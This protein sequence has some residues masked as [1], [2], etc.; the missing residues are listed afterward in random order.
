MTP[1][2][3]DDIAL[4][5]SYKTEF[6]SFDAGNEENKPGDNEMISLKSVVCTGLAAVS[7]SWGCAYA[8][9][10]PVKPVNVIVPYGPGNGLDQLSREYAHAL[11]EQLNI[12]FV[13]ENKEGA[14]GVVGAM[15]AA[16]AAPDGY[17][18]MVAAHPP[19]ATAPLTQKNPGY[20]PLKSFA[21]IAR[22]GSVP[23]I[24]VTSSQSPIT[25]FDVLKSYANENPGKANYASSGIGSPGQ[26]N[27]EII[28]NSTKMNIQEVPYKSTSQALTDVVAGHVLVSIVSAPAAEQL[29]ASGKLRVLGVGSLERLKKFPDV[30]TLTELIHK[31]GYEA[32]VWYG[33]FAPAGTSQERINKLYTEVKKAYS[34]KQVASAM[35]RLSIVPQLQDPQAFSASLR[36]DYDVARQLIQSLNDK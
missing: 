17:T 11:Q 18:I 30:P 12:P 19:Y 13:V 21:P 6:A 23:L 24:L 2:F 25:S 7:F 28:K 14:G 4:F 1:D 26:L 8:E 27:M 15:A 36:Q 22:V 16:R 34:S 33:F 5:H 32:H 35:E 29:V 10:Y 20:E 9:N 3:N 31:P